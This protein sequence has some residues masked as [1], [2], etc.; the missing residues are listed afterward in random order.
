MYLYIMHF[1]RRVEC[2]VQKKKKDALSAWMCLPV[3]ILLGKLR[4]FTFYLKLLGPQIVKVKNNFNWTLL[5]ASDEKG[6][7]KKEKAGK[8]ITAVGGHASGPSLELNDPCMPC[9]RYIAP[10]RTLW[11]G[12]PAC[13]TRTM[14][15]SL[16]RWTRHR[17]SCAGLGTSTASGGW[18]R[19]TRCRKC[20]RRRNV[21]IERRQCQN[22][23]RT[24]W[25]ETETET[26]WG[27]TG[28]I[29]IVSNG[30]ST[31]SVFSLLRRSSAGDV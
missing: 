16:G 6:G 28:Q 13:R 30:W 15:V 24:A 23:R 26:A 2:C 4:P 10:R 11:S 20:W 25:A 22:C 3:V 19:V 5:L 17:R 12:M 27:Q 18:F 21:R 31:S 14:Q 1:W 8:V 7:K 29:T 9:L